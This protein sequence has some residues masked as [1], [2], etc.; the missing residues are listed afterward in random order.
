M[1]STENWFVDAEWGYTAVILMIVVNLCRG[2]LAGNQW[3]SVLLGFTLAEDYTSGVMILNLNNFIHDHSH[4]LFV[5]HYVP[6]EM[7]Y[8][9][10]L[11]I[12]TAS[13]L[14]LHIHGMATIIQ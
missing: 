9:L 14:V 5:S 6:A 8:L 11:G 3:S 1:I 2:Y 10:R 7:T 4:D 12:S 13:Q